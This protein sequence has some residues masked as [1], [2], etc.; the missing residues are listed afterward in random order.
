MGRTA[1]ALRRSSH[2]CRCSDCG[3]QHVRAKLPLLRFCAQCFE[4]LSSAT[5]AKYC[6]PECRSAVRRL[7]TTRR[8]AH[9]AASGDLA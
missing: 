3:A 6:G 1:E 2:L 7:A 4:L 8:P 5:R 9:G